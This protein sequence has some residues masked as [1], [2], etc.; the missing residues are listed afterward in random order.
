MEYLLCAIRSVISSDFLDFDLIIVDDNSSNTQFDKS[1]IENYIKNLNESVNFSIIV[2]DV[3]LGTVK[4]LNKVIPLVKSEFFTVVSGDD[5]INIKSM[6]TLLNFAREGNFDLTG[7]VIHILFKDGSIETEN[8]L[9]FDYLTYN[10]LTALE[11]TKFIASNRLP[12]SRGG[13]LFRTD[14]VHGVGFFDEAYELY[15]DRPFFLRLARANSNLAVVD[16][17]VYTWRNYSGASTNMFNGHSVRFLRDLITLYKKE[18]L[19]NHEVLGL[20]KYKL[21][22]T[23]KKYSLLLDIKNSINN[24]FKL[25]LTVVLNI[26]TIVLISFNKLSK[27]IVNGFKAIIIS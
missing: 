18:Y 16:F 5:L 8:R 20:D 24:P 13:A 14:K 4:T 1:L 23:I 7:G 26:P 25:G 9:P 27:S 19:L 12:F 6:P 11:K 22:L 3:N 21:T 15:D 2:N 10:K 17:H